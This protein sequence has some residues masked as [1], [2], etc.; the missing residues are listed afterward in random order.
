M[1]NDLT[2]E[3]CPSPSPYWVYLCILHAFLIKIIML[4]FL[5]LTST[6]IFI[7]IMTAMN[8]ITVHF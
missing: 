2:D 5:T 6:I 1:I 4:L 7:L 3:L 8:C